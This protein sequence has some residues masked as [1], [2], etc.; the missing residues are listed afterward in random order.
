MDTQPTR[1]ETEIALARSSA[2]FA[3]SAAAVLAVIYGVLAVGHAFLLPPGI[4]EPLMALAGGTALACAV[5]AR[6]WR[7]HGSEARAHGA[8]VA[9]ALLVWANTSLHLWLQPV[10]ENAT[11]FTILL[12]GL[13]LLVTTRRW[14]YPL[15]A[16]ALGS[17]FV[18]AGAHLA[19]DVQ[20]WTWHLL[21]ATT[22]A[23]IAH[24]QRRRTV[25]K[26]IRRECMLRHHA[27]VLQQLM[28]APELGTER[29]DEVLERIVADGAR[30][31]GVARAG[32]W[33]FDH[34]ADAITSIAQYDELG[35][36]AAGLA[37]RLARRDAP[38]YFAALDTERTIAA[39]D[40]RTH[41]A[42][43]E[44]STGYLELLGVDALLDSPILVDGSLLG[45]LCLEHRGGERAWTLEEQSFAA[46]LASLAAL[47][48]QSEERARLERRTQTAERLE[49][50]GLLAG[51]VAHDFNNLLTA[52]LGNAELAASQLGR[53]HPVR[54]DVDTS[55]TPRRAPR[56]S[57]G[58]CSPT[59]AARPSSPR[60]WT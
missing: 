25:R 7:S 57:P 2:E 12:L 22:V 30:T 39:A 20:H 48:I 11:N 15:A 49:S 16:L 45:V 5:L 9:M 33:R 34:G 52:V 4:R 27:E 59:R 54:A 24:E 23:V 36:G 17:W 41:P 38:A 21:F 18:L 37:R 31:L 44:L 60:P 56:I 6:L 29:G 58:R 46:S 13:G 14:F 26:G 32:V 3:P 1:A 47:A 42:T 10:A 19:G 55:S 43:R 53:E 40:A 35:P 51:G 50:L 28:H 8:V